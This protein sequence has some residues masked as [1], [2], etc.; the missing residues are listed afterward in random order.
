MH[1]VRCNW[2]FCAFG[3]TTNVLSYLTIV[4]FYVFLICLIIMCFVLFNGFVLY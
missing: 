1:T 4:D 3:A 2:A